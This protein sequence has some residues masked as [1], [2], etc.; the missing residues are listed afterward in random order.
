MFSTISEDVSPH[1]GE[2]RMGENL[3]LDALY[4]MVEFR[5]FIPFLI[6][7]LLHGY[8]LRVHIG[9]LLEHGGIVV[10]F[11]CI[12]L[13]LERITLLFNTVERGI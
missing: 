2:C 8:G 6:H 10:L 9:N 4:L 3:L 1:I 11:E 12:D 13:V 5:E 7:L